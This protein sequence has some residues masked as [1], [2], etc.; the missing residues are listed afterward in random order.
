MKKI[1][2]S[3]IVMIMLSIC[4]FAAAPQNQIPSTE[5]SCIDETDNDQDGYTDCDD[6][7][8]ALDQTCLE[9]EFYEGNQGEQNVASHNAD[10]IAGGTFQDDINIL[11][12]LNIAHEEEID[13]N[14]IYAKH[15]Y[16]VEDVAAIKGVNS[17]S[18][19]YGL[20]GHSL[21]GTGVY[22][23]SWS[24]YGIEGYSASA[25]GVYGES[26]SDDGV[27]GITYAYDDIG[28]GVYGEANNAAN[29]ID[30]NNICGVR[31]SS[32]NGNHGY[33]GCK[34]HGLYTIQDAYI[35]GELEVDGGCDGCGNDIAE[36]FNAAEKLTPGDIV[37]INQNGEKSLLL[38]TEGYDTTVAGIV[39]TN[40]TIVMGDANGK[41]VPLALSGVVP[42]KVS[43]ENGPI[44]VGDLLTT[45]NTPGHAMKCDDKRKCFG[46]L[47]GK[48]L[49]PLD[50]GTGT[51]IALV[52]LG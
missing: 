21:Y 4:V 41:S 12:I 18:D 49:E 8:C 26:F 46:S 7:D 43:A 30:N 37:V 27:Y 35:G 24:G 33:L 3:L 32:D 50:K 11:G 40:P 31:G 23:Q 20:W 14:L 19:G 22:G 52:M 28:Y 17:D 48:A 42:T 47:V 45:S 36:A 6:D 38:S 15:Y 10:D 16:G 9:Y 13:D 34:N 44:E 25:E 5:T 2:I 39:S 29:S 1:I 51:V